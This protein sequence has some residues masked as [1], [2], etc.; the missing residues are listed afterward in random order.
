MASLY[1]IEASLAGMLPTLW[2][3]LGVGLPWAFALLSTKH[4]RSKAFIGA[5]ALALGPAWMTTWMLVLGFV[6]AQLNTPLLTPEWILPGSLAIA[7]A[8]AALAWRKRQRNEVRSLSAPAGR[9]ADN[10]RTSRSN[11]TISVPSVVKKIYVTFAK[12]NAPAQRSAASAPSLAFDEKLIIGL[13][14]AAVVLRWIHTAFW[15]FTAYDALWIFGYQGRLY[16][17]EGLIPN[18]ID[19][20]PPFLSL[21]FAYVQTLVGDINDHAARMVIP[22]LHIGSI[23]AAYLLGKRLTNRRVGIFAAALWSLHPYVGQWAPIGDLEIPLTFSFTLAAVFFLRAWTCEGDPSER[24]HEAL[25]AGVMLGLAMFTKPTAGAFIWGI[26]LLLAVD[27]IHKRFDFRRW[28]PRLATACWTV[29]ACLPLGAPWYL[30]N[31][32]LGHEAIT[33]PKAIWL[34][35]ALRSGDYLAPL[36]LALVL[37]VIVLMMRFQ[38]KGRALLI[39]AIGIALLLA[40]AQASSFRLSPQ[41]V[42]PPASYITA[43]DSALIIAGLILVGISLRGRN[44]TPLNPQEARLLRAGGW[45]LLFALPYFVTFFFSYSYHYRLGFAALPLLCLPS[46]IALSLILEPARMGRWSGALRRATYLALFCLS[47]PGVAASALDMRWSSLPLLDETLD[48]DIRKYQAFNPSLLEMVFGLNDYARDT[49]REAIVLAPGEERLPFF[50]PQLRMIDEP[51]TRLEDYEN[52]GATHFIYGAKAREAYAEAGLDPRETQLVAALGRVDLFQPVREHFD[53]TFSYE[54]YESRDI[55]GRRELPGRYLADRQS[56]AAIT[57]DGQLRLHTLGAFPS[58]I[59]VGTPITLELTWRAL[60]PLDRRLEFV[61]RF[62]NA[63]TKQT[64]QTWQLRAAPHRHGDYAT[65]FWETDE[66][67]KDRRIL[68]LDDEAPLKRE[69]QPYIF[70]VGVWDPQ[71]ER[72]LDLAIDGLSAGQFYQLPG[73]YKLRT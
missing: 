66:Y 38:L 68:R 6:G 34:T 1:W 3:H 50:F 21:Q 9:N 56:P 2:M 22:M 48:S 33:W 44:R 4:W 40:G 8:G 12:W 16:F 42:D 57:Y 70:S 18:A 5:L 20:Y 41:R 52:L 30:R 25:L 28:R 27:L 72:F 46:A 62:Q 65:T 31:V 37:A 69:G 32:A 29:V 23:L 71:A 51:V 73:I 49:G 58:T 61:I 19:Y 45:A 11:Q 36:L 55:G 13:I 53:G 24:R 39:C 47:L 15:P 7:V 26:L 17:L 43:E 14:A 60:E 10:I 54:L 64:A 67:V 59:F 63:D 35:R